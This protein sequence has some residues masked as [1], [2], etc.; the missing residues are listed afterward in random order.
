MITLEDRPVCPAWAISLRGLREPAAVRTVQRGDSRG[1]GGLRGLISGLPQPPL[2]HSEVQ[3][4][5]G[6]KEKKKRG[7]GERQAGPAWSEPPPQ[8]APY[9]LNNSPQVM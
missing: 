2:S 3:D 8:G 5:G 1:V 6:M 7:W 4:A 9:T